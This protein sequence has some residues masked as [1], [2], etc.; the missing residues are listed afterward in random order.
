MKLKLLLF[1]SSI[2]LTSL[3][4]AQIYDTKTLEVNTLKVALQ[5]NGDM[6]RNSGLTA[7]IS[8]F[9]N[10]SGLSCVY[11]QSMWMGGLNQNSELKLAANAYRTSGNDFF[12]GPVASSYN[13]TYDSFYNNVWHLT[14]TE[15]ED[16]I[17]N[18]STTGYIVPDAIASWPANGNTGNGE[19]TNLAPY[20]D[21]NTNNIYEPELG[22][23]P[24]IRG[25]EALFVIYNDDRSVHTESGGDKIGV[26]IHLMLYAFENNGEENNDQVVF[27]HYEIYNRSQNNNFSSFYV[28]SWLDFDIGSGT[29][30]FIGTNTAQN[31]IYAYN[32]N[33]IDADYG[34]NPPAYGYILLNEPLLHSMYYNSNFDP[35][36]GSP[37]SPPQ[38]YNY[39]IGRWKNGTPLLNPSDSTLIDFIFPGDSDTLNYP[40]W[41]E[42]NSGNIPSDRRMLGSTYIEDF[43]PGNKICLDF[44]S[45]FAR[46]NTL[47]HIDQLNHLFELGSDVQDFYNN[48]YDDCNDLSD[49]NLVELDL[50]NNNLSIN[51]VNNQL[52]L[53]ANQPLESDL[54]IHMIDLLGRTVFQGV[55]NQGETTLTFQIPYRETN[56]FIIQCMNNEVN[57]SVKI[58]VRE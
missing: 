58:I 3:I 4:K 22:E 31:M 48:Q 16:H 24:L 7:S 28:S 39:M 35:Q 42:V 6:H 34:V 37:V 54:K 14:R 26:E 38:Y 45:V 36:S 49:L 40:N 56:V 46:D 55:L 18:Y 43:E 13:S 2:L 50:T 25:D 57:E 51:Q 12:P 5:A 15:V 21:L 27:S 53:N 17:A 29:D 1:S 33:P 52:I 41:S 10:G 32:G 9:P 11:A 8:E 30:D 19:A 44:A 47:S 23:H 20:A